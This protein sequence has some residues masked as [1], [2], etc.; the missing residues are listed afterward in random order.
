MSQIIFN[1]IYDLNEFYY[2]ISKKLRE[3][4]TNNKLSK[5][6]LAQKINIGQSIIAK[7]ESGE[8][9]LSIDQLWNISQK[10]EWKLEII[11]E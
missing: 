9:A 10:L 11:I 5:K 2:Q 8:Y 3:Y 1:S 4:R 6:Q 7:L